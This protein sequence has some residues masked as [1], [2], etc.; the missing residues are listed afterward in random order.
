MDGT[1][2]IEEGDLSDFLNIAVQNMYALDRHWS[3]HLTKSIVRS[4][5]R[6]IQK[7][8]LRRSRENVSHH[9]DLSKELFESFLDSDHQH[10]CAYFLDPGED[11]ESAQEN[12]RRII[13]AKPRL[14]LGQH[15]LGIG[16]GWRGLAIALAQSADVEVMGITLSE[17][18]HKVSVDRA[19]RAGIAD[20]VRFVLKEYRDVTGEFDRIVSVDMF[21]HV[22]L[23]HYPKF[24]NKC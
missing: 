5:S 15:V 12:K 13:A 7:N 17:E 20:R 3:Q 21:E 23:S 18:Q 8:T 19:M 22:G 14:E 9:Y 16:S 2:T 6:L 4:A 1:L 24:F 11:L 10:S